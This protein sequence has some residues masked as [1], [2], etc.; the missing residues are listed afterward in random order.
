MREKNVILNS[1][2]RIVLISSIIIILAISFIFI[3]YWDG[4]S[5]LL[6]NYKEKFTLS[7]RLSSISKFG[8]NLEAVDEIRIMRLVDHEPLKHL[9]RYALDYP[10]SLYI[11]EEKVIIGNEARE[12][13]NLWRKLDFGGLSSGC[14]E[15]H[16]VV[17]FRHEEEI[18]FESVVCFICGNLTL[19]SFP[20]DIL[21]GFEARSDEAKLNF[22]L[23]KKVC[24][25]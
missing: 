19:P 13:A 3:L 4:V 20:S 5:G 14:F 10:K 16:H 23:F 25:E 2:R 15:P 17:Q 9:G 12:I 11:L 21:V 6:G 8:I 22:S 18:L 7:R 24:E 1:M